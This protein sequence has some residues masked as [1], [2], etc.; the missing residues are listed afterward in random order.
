V[1]EIKY[2]LTL[3]RCAGIAPRTTLFCLLEISNEPKGELGAFLFCLRA[4]DWLG[5]I[6]L[7]KK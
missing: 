4:A 7:L 3:V 5:G 1:K 6:S 2:S